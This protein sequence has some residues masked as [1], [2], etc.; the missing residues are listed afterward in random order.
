MEHQAGMPVLM[1][2]LSG[3][4]RDVNAF[5]QV[6]RAHI[7][8][9]PTTDGTTDLVADRALYRE[10]NLQPVANTQLKWRTRVPAPWSA[11]Q[12]GL[13]QAD[14]PTMTPLADG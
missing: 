1:Q 12:A 2:P 11:A 14:P 9:W 8:P 13:S 6:G 5:G 3:T 4:S 7:A 10:A